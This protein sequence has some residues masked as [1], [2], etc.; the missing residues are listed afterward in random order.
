MEHYDCTVHQVP[1]PSDVFKQYKQSNILQH[2]GS[3]PTQT[4]DITQGIILCMCSVY[5][6]RS[7]WNIMMLPS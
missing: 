4:Y 1:E 6:N 2:M 3:V 7:L 5:P